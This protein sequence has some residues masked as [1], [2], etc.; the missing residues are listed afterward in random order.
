MREQEKNR[1]REGALL[2]V[3]QKK[4]KI[5]QPIQILREVKKSAKTQNQKKEEKKE[6]EH[7]PVL[8]HTHTHTH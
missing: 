7:M 1:V 5:S 8:M 4:K 3:M 6:Q 2:K